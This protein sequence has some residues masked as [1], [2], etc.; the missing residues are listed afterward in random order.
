MS[1]GKILDFLKWADG[2][3]WGPFL[4][5]S[6]LGTGS[7]LMIR[8]QFLPI[9]RL[10][11]A[12]LCAVGLDRKK[13]CRE[14]DKAQAGKKA[15]GSVSPVAALMNELATTIGLD[16]G[17]C[18]YWNGDQTDGEY[19]FCKIPD[20]EEKWRAGWRSH[21][22]HGKRVKNEKSWQSPGNLILIFCRLCRIRN[23]EYDA[24]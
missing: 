22:C 7:Y 24:G 15:Q 1:N 23:G 3:V 19:A 6:L 17:V 21:V 10:K 11:Y 8:L 2:I 18:I 4:L 9:R 5:I 12:L 20:P 16:D 14:R 13:V